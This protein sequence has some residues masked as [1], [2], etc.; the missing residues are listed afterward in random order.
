MNQRQAVQWLISTGADVNMETKP[1]SV[2]DSAPAAAQEGDPPLALACVYANIEL[3]KLLLRKGADHVKSLARME[4][5]E[6]RT[7]ELA[8]GF[9][10]LQNG[11]HPSIYAILYI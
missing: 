4:R 11:K 9:K 7:E 10:W 1:F 8:E 5:Y 6:D 3:A 2:D